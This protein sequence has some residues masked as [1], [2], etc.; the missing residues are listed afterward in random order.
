MLNRITNSNTGNDATY[1][2]MGGATTA[3]Y[4][5][6]LAD[7]TVMA[8]DEEMAAATR[9]VELRKALWTALLNYP[10][11]IAAICQ[12]LN[13]RLSAEACPPAVVAEV[14]KTARALRDRVLKV[15]EEAFAAARSALIE[16]LVFADVDS[17]AS[18]AILAD[19]TALEG[20]RAVATN[21]K[22]KPPYRDSA[23]FFR[24]V[25]TARRAHNALMLAKN[26]FVRSNLRLVVAIA[27]RFG[28]SQ[29]PM[30]DLIQDGNIGLMKAV[31]R[32]DP[33]RGCRFATYAAW[34]IRYAITRA[35][36]DT[37]RSVRLP[38]HMIDACKKVNRAR[39]EYEVMYGR[40]PTEEELSS[41]TGI[42]L[43]RIQRMSWS[44]IDQPLSLSLPATR[45]GDSCLA[46]TLVDG[47]NVAPSDLLDSELLQSQLLEVFQK[48]SPIEA[49][50]LRKRVGMDGEPELTLKE[51][52]A[53]YSLSRERIRQLQEQ[54]LRKIRTEFSRRQ[55]M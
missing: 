32:F 28:R 48:L 38:L 35:I 19:L 25:A 49:D 41:A 5:R 4:F 43:E 23:P 51:I 45:D 15:H 55:L 54:A 22:V 7:V 11:F 30:Q 31:D 12:L 27:R 47:T 21:L 34:W 44:L 20:N 10:P 39:R 37:D 13:E 40:A 2:S 36:V 9:L 8:K 46:D 24:Y 50:I 53:T 14:E 6:E 16:K 1:T 33:A 52:G 29:I 17:V 26:E 18:D 42:S 3:Q